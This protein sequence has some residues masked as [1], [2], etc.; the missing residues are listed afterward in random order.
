L[1]KPSENLFGVIEE[2]DQLAKSDAIT[3]TVRDELSD[4]A[5]T[6]QPI[7]ESLQNIEKYIV[8]PQGED[9][10]NV[11]DFYNSLTD[12]RIKFDD[13]TGELLQ[14]SNI[15]QP[16]Y[17]R[18][19][20][21]V[22]L[23]KFSQKEQ[24]ISK[25]IGDN[26][27][28]IA[29]ALKALR[30]TIKDNKHDGYF[31]SQPKRDDEAFTKLFQINDRFKLFDL[32]LYLIRN[33]PGEKLFKFDPHRNSRVKLDTDGMLSF[34]FDDS[35]IRQLVYGDW[36]SCYVYNIIHDQAARFTNPCEI[37]SL[38]TY[39]SPG[40]VSAHASDFD[41]LCRF[42]NNIV[43]IECKSGNI[44]PRIAEGIKQRNEEFYD[45][46]AKTGGP[47][48]NLQSVLVFDPYLNDF[49]ETVRLLNRTEFEAIPPNK[50]RLLVTELFNNRGD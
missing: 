14:L 32:R 46:L 43:L 34:K 5:S 1:K 15:F 20:N 35:S 17:T 12:G 28:V 50:V 44:D 29:P 30:S 23:Y 33:K 37:Y 19:F 8:F 31:F 48:L 47:E 11:I 41:V 9:V 21:F 2:I 10:Q 16:L 3:T 49:E 4:I 7:L 22:S 13:V 24:A 26:F 40:D 45:V 6:I 25:Q 42:G 27:E 18:G 38:V 39:K 36:L